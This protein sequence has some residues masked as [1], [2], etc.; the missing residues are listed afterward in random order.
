MEPVWPVEFGKYQVDGSA[1]PFAAML[2]AVLCL[3]IVSLW[4]ET[5]SVG[6]KAV[7]LWSRVCKH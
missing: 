1:V 7:T 4:C 2:L 6:M 3:S 5:S